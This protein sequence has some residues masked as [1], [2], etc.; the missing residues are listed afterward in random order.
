MAAALMARGID[1]RAAALA[2]KVGMAALVEATNA[3][4]V[5]DSGQ[6]IAHLDAT[7]AELQNLT[8]SSASVG[9]RNKPHAG[10]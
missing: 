8:S 4:L 7:F 3:W 9:F 1:K 6:F 10:V 5:D 2:A